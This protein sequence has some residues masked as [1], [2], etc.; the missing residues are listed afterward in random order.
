MGYHLTLVKT[1]SCDTGRLSHMITSTVPGSQLASDV[2][3]ELTF[4]LPFTSSQHFPTLLDTLESKMASPVPP[5]FSSLLYFSLSFI[6]SHLLFYRV[7]SGTSDK[8][9]SEIGTT[10]LYTCF[11]P[12]ANTVVY[13]FTSEIGTTS[14]QGTKLL[15]PKCPLFGGFTVHSTE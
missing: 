1:P 13:Y 8:G 2:S 7:Y 11:D 10:S 4:L 9:P 12:H 14:L 15:A 3:A 5:L 6:F